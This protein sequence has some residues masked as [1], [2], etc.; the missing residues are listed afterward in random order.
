M[1]IERKF[2]T[3]EIPFSLEQY[4]FAKISQSYISFSPTIRIRQ[5]D[6]NYFL[7][8][9]GKGHLAREEF[10]MQL[11]KEQYQALEKKCD[12]P[13]VI[14]KRYYVP[15]K[16]NLVAEIDFYEGKSKGLITTEVEFCS[17]QA[18]TC[19]VAPDWFGKEV[20]FDSRYKNTNLSLHGIPQTT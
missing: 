13:P 16:D 6:T 12:T 9:K 3:K 11:T 20:T 5:S 7:T 14:K 18:A 15:L 19:F 8:V 4:R 17:E 2:L 1:E 10:E